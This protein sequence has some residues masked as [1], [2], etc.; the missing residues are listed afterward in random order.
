M[1]KKD[2]T[3]ATATKI[4]ICHICGEMIIGDCEYIKT[5]RRTEMYFRPQCMKRGEK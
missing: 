4:K 3:V 5:K 2:K 1:D